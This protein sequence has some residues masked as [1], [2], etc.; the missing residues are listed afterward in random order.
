[1]ISFQQ[2][3]HRI[4][5]KLLSPRLRLKSNLHLVIRAVEMGCDVIT[6]EQ[7]LTLSPQ[8]QVLSDRQ[9]RKNHRDCLA[10]ASTIVGNYINGENYRLKVV[11]VIEDSVSLNKIFFCIF[12]SDAIDQEEKAR[13]NL[14]LQ[15]HNLAAY[16][17]TTRRILVIHDADD[18]NVEYL[19]AHQQK[20]QNYGNG[21]IIHII[22]DNFSPELKL[23]LWQEYRSIIKPG[24]SDGYY[25]RLVLRLESR[26]C[27]ELIEQAKIA[28][29]NSII[30]NDRVNIVREY[31]EV[32]NPDWR[33]HLQQ[34]EQLG[35]NADYWLT[36]CVRENEKELVERA[37]SIYQQKTLRHNFVRNPIAYW[38]Y[39]LDN[40]DTVEEYNGFR[41]DCPAGNWRGIVV[42]KAW[43]RKSN[44]QI[45]LAL[46]I[47][48]Y[49]F[50]EYANN[51][52][53][54][55]MGE[56]NLAR[57]EIGQS[58]KIETEVNVLGHSRIVRVRLNK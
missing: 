17:Y 57:V 16:Y 23:K 13:F 55:R 29:T 15:K 2:D 20:V 35:I 39:I 25:L 41:N 21:W 34:M 28:E 12:A 51:N 10:F 14:V 49:F 19:C 11:P 6:I 3:Y 50:N 1:M 46:D 58:L 7:L 44:I 22:T 33:S 30:P 27:S 47:G 32:V 53:T 52:Y 43:G 40:L 8:T 9:V 42:R 48:N 31:F 45:F 37:I 26:Y 54:P 36:V 56:V 5:K 4:L 24:W 38:R 18:I